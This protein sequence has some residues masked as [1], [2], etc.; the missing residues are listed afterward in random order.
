MK[1]SMITNSSTF[2]LH[3]LLSLGLILESDWQ[4]GF[5]PQ[6]YVELA[7]QILCCTLS[8]GRLTYKFHRLVEPGQDLL[9]EA[10]IDRHTQEVWLRNEVGLWARVTGIEDIGD[11]ILLHQLLWWKGIEQ[12]R[13]SHVGTTSSGDC[14][15]ARFPTLFSTS[16]WQPK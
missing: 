16:R 12:V 11:I 4:V 6:K 5:K 8:Q 9:A 14:E 13:T 15:A 2:Y 1:M 7:H 3:S 10:V